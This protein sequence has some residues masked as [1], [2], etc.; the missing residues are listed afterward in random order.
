MKNKKKIQFLRKK[1]NDQEVQHFRNHEMIFLWVWDK[2]LFFYENVRVWRFLCK[3]NSARLY[4][5][6]RICF[7]L[8]RDIE[9]NTRQTARRQE[10]FKDTLSF[11]ST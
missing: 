9:I 11:F 2:Y 5:V 6:W 4:I 10:A 7:A 8:R 3:F 1:N